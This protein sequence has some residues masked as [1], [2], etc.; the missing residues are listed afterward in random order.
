MCVWKHVD[1]SYA[2]FKQHKQDVFVHLIKKTQH[3][4]AF[5]FITGI[6]FFAINFILI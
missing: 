1:E 3:F 4:I 5:Q 6:S 2:A